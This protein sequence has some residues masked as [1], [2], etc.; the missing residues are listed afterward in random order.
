[1]IRSRL[2]N[3]TNK[4]KNPSGILKFKRQRNLVAD[5]SNEAKLQ[6]SEELNVGYNSKPFCKACKTYFSNKNSNI[7]EYVF[8]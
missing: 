4:S 7:E 1:M 6:Y 8:Y 5:L 3:K 2:E